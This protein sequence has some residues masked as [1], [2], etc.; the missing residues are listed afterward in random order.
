MRFGQVVVTWQPLELWEPQQHGRL[1]VRPPFPASGQLPHLRQVRF[2][3]PWERGLQLMPRVLLLGRLALLHGE[4][5]AFLLFSLLSGPQHR[6]EHAVQL[7]YK[8]L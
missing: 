4:Q 5:E 1:K 7:A 8:L 3:W 2:T 6:Q